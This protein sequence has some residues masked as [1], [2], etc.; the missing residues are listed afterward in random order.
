M[1]TIGHTIVLKLSFFF[2]MLAGHHISYQAIAL[3]F[4]VICQT[5]TLSK[6]AD[7]SC[8]LDMLCRT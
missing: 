8:S 2:S 6:L 5:R 3:F 7:R 1:Y 4:L